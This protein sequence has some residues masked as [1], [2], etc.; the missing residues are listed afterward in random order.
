MDGNRIANK[1]VRPLLM[2]VMT[3]RVKWVECIILDAASTPKISHMI[4]D[5][6]NHQIHTGTVQSLR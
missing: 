4:G 5:N 2:S 1:L 3:H 6:I